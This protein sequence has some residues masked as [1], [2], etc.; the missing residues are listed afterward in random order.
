MKISKQQLKQ[1]IKEELGRTIINRT[2]GWVNENLNEQNLDIIV[3]KLGEISVKLNKLFDI[4]TS[5]DYL[6]AAITGED[7]FTLG[8]AQKAMGRALAPP[9]IKAPMK[10]GLIDDM[11]QRYYGP[12]DTWID[13]I[14]LAL[15]ERDLMKQPIDP[16]DTTIPF[17]DDPADIVADL[18]VR[19]LASIINNLYHHDELVLGFD[20]DTYKMMDDFM[21]VANGM[22]PNYQDAYKLRELFGGLNSGLDRKL[23]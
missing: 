16:V 21:A 1:V 10:E 18:P 8:V 13:A 12:E 4:D 14:K 9:K 6:A 15:S 3:K 20:E 22:E 19:Q 5:I 17:N 7:P 2:A 11:H 23:P